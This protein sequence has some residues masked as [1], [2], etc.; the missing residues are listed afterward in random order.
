MA[1]PT[2]PVDGVATGTVDGVATRPVDGIEAGAVD[3]VATRTVDG[4]DTHRYF[5]GI[6]EI[7][8]T[9]ASRRCPAS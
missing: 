7:H 4:L 8:S 3:G 6:G 9:S 2:R 1:L 5:T